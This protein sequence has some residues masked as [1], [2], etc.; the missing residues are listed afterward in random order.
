MKR[1]A[2]YSSPIVFPRESTL[3]SHDHRNAGE[4]LPPS[5]E[6]AKLTLQFFGQIATTALSTLQTLH[7]I[8][9]AMSLA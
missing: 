2:T 7:F 4:G 9:R 1:R 3:V 6:D 8:F 5:R